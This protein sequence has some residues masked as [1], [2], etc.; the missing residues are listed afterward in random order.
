MGPPHRR[1]YTRLALVGDGRFDIRLHS[2]LPAPVGAQSNSYASS[3]DANGNIFGIGNDVTTG[4]IYAVEWSLREAKL[5]NTSTR[6]RVLTG[7][8]VLIGGFILSGSGTKSMLL[9]GLGPTLTQF[10]IADALVDP[11]LELQTGGWAL[12]ASNN[13]WRNTQQGQIA[14]TGKASPN[15]LELAILHSYG[16]GNYTAILSGVNETSGTAL[17]EAYSLEA[18]TTIQ[19]SNISTRWFCRHR[20][21]SDDRWVHC[22][23]L[24][25][26]RPQRDYPRA[27]TNPNPVW[28][29]GRVP[30]FDSGFARRERQP[31][32]V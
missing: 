20:Q 16:P 27:R 29:S 3:I 26:Q 11:T 15:D 19:L 28:R 17:V 2:L 32:C 22:R 1:I 30:R 12:I 21:C 18:G 10:G 25:R 5:V 4:S 9:R 8:N 7:A 6:L 14:A 31:D 13:N 23:W 24:T